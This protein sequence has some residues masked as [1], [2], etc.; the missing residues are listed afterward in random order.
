MS[1][2]PVA[3]IA[4]ERS[5]PDGKVHQAAVLLPPAEPSER[6]TIVGPDTRI[7]PLPLAPRAPPNKSTSASRACRA[8]GGG[9]GWPA[10]QVPSISRAAIPAMRRCGPSA[11]QTGPSP[12]Q[13]AVGVQVK[14]S[15]AAT[16]TAARANIIIG[17]NATA[18]CGQ[19]KAPARRCSPRGAQGCSSSDRKG[20]R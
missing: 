10:R 6:Q 16:T 17:T 12:S 4:Q 13:T 20:Y 3:T 19:T 2:V 18:T 5:R 14:V 9:Q 11:H 8:V 7:W 1:T 15:P